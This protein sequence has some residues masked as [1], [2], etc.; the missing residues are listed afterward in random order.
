MVSGA[1]H[2][3][4]N[5]QVRLARCRVLAVR[6]DSQR[7]AGSDG[8]GDARDARDG[9]PPSTSSTIPAAAALLR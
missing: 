6:L 7:D 9:D 8:R 5:V 3:L 2:S 4:N 1:Y